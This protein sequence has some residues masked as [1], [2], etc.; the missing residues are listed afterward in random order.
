MILF[1]LLTKFA[2]KIQI[3]L[4]YV[5]NE[6]R[7]ELWNGHSKPISVQIYMEK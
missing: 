6:K 1:V 7:V 5:I 4:Q 3:Q 2:S